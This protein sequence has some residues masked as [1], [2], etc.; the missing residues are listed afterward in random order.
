MKR[1]G[2]GAFHHAYCNGREGVVRLL[3]S[4]QLSPLYSL[5]VSGSL[6]VHLL[7]IGKKLKRKKTRRKDRLHHCCYFCTPLFS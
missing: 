5:C 7:T 6:L 3:L 1:A 2:G 4:L